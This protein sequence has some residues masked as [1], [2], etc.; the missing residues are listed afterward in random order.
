MKSLLAVVLL[1]L[2]ACRP[3]LP[4]PVY[5]EVAEFQLTAQTGQQFPSRSLRG[6]IWVADFIFTNCPGPCP[7]MSSQMRGIQT[8]VASM[9]DV[10]L[11]SFTVDPQRDTPAVLAQYAARYHAEPGRWFFL[12]GKPAVLEAVCRNDF[13]LGDVDG[14]LVH[15]TRF[16]L[17]DRRSRV[18]G[19]YSLTED[20]GISRLL[21]DIRKLHGENS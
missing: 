13:K 15:S 5:W 3:E 1:A 19:F 16:V 9:P 10:K 6:N 8:A 17:L 21:H 11:V 7:R 4:L 2:A 18:R 12:T 20:D 14:S